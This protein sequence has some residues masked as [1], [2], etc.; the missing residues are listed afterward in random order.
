M[1]PG[2]KVLK[3]RVKILLILMDFLGIS[4]T[5]NITVNCHE[6]RG[7]GTNIKTPVT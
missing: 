5:W 4:K 6:R 2:G 7:N 1:H 3:Q